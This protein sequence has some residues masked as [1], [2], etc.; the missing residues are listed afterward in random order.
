VRGV[1]RVPD[2]RGKDLDLAF[3]SE[4]I[5]ARIVSWLHRAR[6]MAADAPGR[7]MLVAV[8]DGLNPTRDP[9]DQ[10]SDLVRAHAEAVADRNLR[11]VRV[12]HGRGVHVAWLKDLAAAAVA[13]GRGSAPVSL[14]WEPEHGAAVQLLLLALRDEE[15]PPGTAFSLEGWSIT[16]ASVLLQDLRG[17]GTQPYPLA[18]FTEHMREHGGAISHE[19][20]HFARTHCEDLFAQAG[21]RVHADHGL[22]G[23][24]AVASAHVALLARWIDEVRGWAA[25]R[26][27]DADGVLQHVVGSMGIA[28]PAVAWM[29]VDAATDRRPALRHAQELW[30]GAT[31]WPGVGRAERLPEAPG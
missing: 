3:D 13:R 19:L 26:R 15:G 16:H 11:Y 10:A 30:D 6:A 17:T 20:V 25:G 24:A 23:V 14:Q 18:L 9:S 4:R 2:T 29:L 28:D 22:P 5:R 12:L 8:G 7:V 1:R 21:P 31:P 27:G